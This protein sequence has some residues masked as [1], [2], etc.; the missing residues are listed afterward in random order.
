MVRP[1]VRTAQPTEQEI[2]AFGNM[3]EQPPQTRQAP[4]SEAVRKHKE[5]KITGYNFRMT[6][7]QQKL[8]SHAAETEDI[9]QQ[10]L[11]ERIVWPALAE[12]YGETTS[13]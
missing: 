11:L 8:L 3:A 10:K 9:S 4:P 5:P 7:S 13:K 2:E 6:A 1:R 12:R